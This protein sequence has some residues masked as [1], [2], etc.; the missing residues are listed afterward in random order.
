M[1]SVNN[2]KIAIYARFSSDKQS[3]ASIEDQIHRARERLRQEGM[4]PDTATVF[5]DYAVSGASMDRPG[6]R[7]LSQAVESGAVDL[8]IAESLDRISRDVGDADRFRKML[9][10]RRAELRC[11]DGTTV[12]AGDKSS[13]LLYGVRSLFAEAYLSDLGDKTLRGLEGRAR[14]GKATGAAPYGFTNVRSETGSSIA[15]DPERAPI[16]RRIFRMYAEGKSFAAIADTLNREGISPPRPHIR[17]TA[18]GWM[19]T[20]IRSMLLNERYIGRWTFGEREWVKV[21]GTNRRVPRPRT[22]GPLVDMARPELAVVDAETWAA[23]RAR[24]EG[25]DGIARTAR[26]NY[27]LSGILRC[28]ACGGLMTCIGGKVR[29]YGCAVALKRGPEVC[30]HKASARVEDIEQSFFAK[31]VER[32]RSVLPSIVELARDEIAAWSKTRDGRHALVAREREQ[33]QRELTNVSAAIGTTGPL[34]SLLERLRDLDARREVLT[35]E[36]QRLEGDAPVLPHPE[37][38]G[39]RVA[40]LAALATAEPLTTRAALTSLLEGG[41]IDCHHEHDGL[42]LRWSISGDVMLAYAQKQNPRTGS[43]VQGYAVMVA[44]ALS[45][46]GMP[47]ISFEVFVPHR[48]RE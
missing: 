8:V 31:L 20:A 28:A 10:H 5:T 11:L 14:A 6:M 25:R 3:D 41:R 38:L 23:I 9:A 36:S 4:D 33:V 24:F 29:R 46:D 21:P 7:A 22:S 18:A 19:D 30:S 26:T 48:G 34:P 15:I 35:A 16:V 32:S 12:R 45:A 42:T 44:G 2:K 37:S 47:S 43:P 39:Q 27:R 13:A 40:S 1:G 17:R